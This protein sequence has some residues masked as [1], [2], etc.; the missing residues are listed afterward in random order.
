MTGRSL[1]SNRFIVDLLVSREALSNAV[2]PTN[3]FELTVCA[4]ADATST[5]F[6]AR[7]SAVVLGLCTL[8]VAASGS[9]V[10]DHITRN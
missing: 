2:L 8:L 10:Y 3:G 5:I 9:V 7:S 6:S 4:P 1:P